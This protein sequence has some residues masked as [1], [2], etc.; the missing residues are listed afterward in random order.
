MTRTLLGA[1]AFASAVGL[2]PATD[3]PVKADAPLELALVGADKLDRVEVRVAVDGVPVPAVWAE[4]FTKL[5]A[6]FDRNADGSL[7]APEAARLPAARALRLAMGNGFTP[8]VGA[9]PAFAELDRDGDGR[10]TPAEL[11][12]YYRVNGVGDVLVGV[13]RLPAGPA[14]TAALLKHLD[15]DGDGKVVGTEWRAAADALRKLDRNDDELVGAGELVPTAVY[16]GAAGTVLLT[17]PTAGAAP[18]DVVA[19]LPLVLLPADVKDSHWA[20]ELA[21]RSPRLKPDD[22]AAWRVRAPAARWDINLTDGPARFAFAGAVRI[23]GWAAAGGVAEVRDAA[24]KQIAGERDAPAPKSKKGRGAGGL[25]WLVAVADRN[26]DGD[27]DQTELDAW[28]DLQAQ[29]ARGQVLLTVLDGA[30]L[31]EFLDTDHDGALSVREL[32]GAWDRL[33]AAGC[34]TAGA[35][36][37]AKLPRGSLAAAS[38]GYPKTLAA[39]A[40]SGPAWFQAMDR[41]SDG[42]VSRREFTGPADVF[43]R[44]DRDRNG[45]LSPDEVERVTPR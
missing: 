13:G 2:S 30:G 40:R 44:L 22:P 36:D 43:D 14:L 8:P 42:D 9:A 33:A 1:L 32:R 19:Q 21:R 3:P 38:R 7:D 37:A 28:L 27:L 25:G 31:F 45:L 6:Y 17:P 20:A 35:F 26:G 11:A 4:T 12:A 29:V 24:R 23:D 15:T 10:V 5:S 41:N 18:P 34:V 39:R 16:P